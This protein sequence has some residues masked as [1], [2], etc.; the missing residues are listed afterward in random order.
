MNKGS[1]WQSTVDQNGTKVE[2]GTL[3]R[4]LAIDPSILERLEANERS[5]VQAMLGAELEVYE[6]DARGGAWVEM[7]WHPS[8]DRAMS[9]SL[10]LAPSEMEV[11]PR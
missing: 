6:V 11:V 5:A 2:V 1:S 10:G 9:H 7:W 3:V 8:E 4:V